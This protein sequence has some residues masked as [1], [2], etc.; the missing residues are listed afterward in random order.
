MNRAIHSSFVS[1]NGESG[2]YELKADNEVIEFK[3]PVSNLIVETEETEI[4]I[5]INNIKDIWYISPHRVEGIKNL[6]IN[7]IQILN[8]LGTRIKYKALT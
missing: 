4:G 6:D 8:S 7:K 5:K 1:S 2:W 3:Y